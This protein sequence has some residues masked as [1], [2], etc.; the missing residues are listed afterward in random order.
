M[1]KTTYFSEEFHKIYDFHGYQNYMAR[2]IE[3]YKGNHCAGSCLIPN[4]KCEEKRLYLTVIVIQ[5]EV[6]FVQ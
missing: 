2:L 6:E 4:K 3:I 5:E 1:K